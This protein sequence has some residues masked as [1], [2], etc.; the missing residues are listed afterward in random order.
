MTHPVG[1][2]PTE[3][4]HRYSNTSAVASGRGMAEEPRIRVVRL[5]NIDGHDLTE[6]KSRLT[7]PEVLQLRVSRCRQT[8]LDA[9]QKVLVEIG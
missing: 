3:V 7:K 2:V 1:L 8:A 6:K 9:G 5:Q 4:A